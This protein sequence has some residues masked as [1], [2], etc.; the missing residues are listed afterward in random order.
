MP[1]AKGPPMIV[2]R[3]Q[4]RWFWPGSIAVKEAD[5]LLVLLFLI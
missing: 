4:P 1:E 3:I 5:L 2:G